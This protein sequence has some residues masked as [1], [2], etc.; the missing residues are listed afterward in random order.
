MVGILSTWIGQVF[1]WG[2]PQ[3]VI[4]VL[5]VVAARR[6]KLRGMWLI[7]AAAILSFLLKVALALVVSLIASKADSGRIFAPVN[8]YV[9]L[10][11]L[12]VA[13][14]GW[15]MLAFCQRVPNTALQ[16]TAAPPRS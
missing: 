16:A 8:F 15:T 1:N 5:A 2:I 10:L 14:V 12:V 13:I 7:A 4:A 11:A 9:Q 3:L 6:H